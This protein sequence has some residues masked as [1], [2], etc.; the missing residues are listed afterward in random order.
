MRILIKNCSII[1]MIEPDDVYSVGQIEIEG[2]RI[3]YAG[4]VR[5]TDVKFDKVI[6][7]S[8]MVALPGLINSHTHS[9]M[10]LMRGYGDDTALMKWL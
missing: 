7:G 9:S 2:D 6:D 5:D 4:T 10:S 8:G 3:A 1:T